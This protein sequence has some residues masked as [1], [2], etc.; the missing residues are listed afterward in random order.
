MKKIFACIV[1]GTIAA[2][3]VVAAD[4]DPSAAQPPPQ[5]KTHSV[6]QSTWPVWLDF[7]SSNSQ[8]LD[9]IGLHLNMPYGAYESITGLDFG[10]YGVVRHMYGLQINILRSDTL[11]FGGGL[12]FSIYNSFGRMDF[13]SIQLGLWN[14]ATSVR[15]IQLGLIN[16]AGSG[17]G[18][19][20]GLINR[21]DDFHGYQFG[22][23]NLIY[24][25]SAPCLPFVNIGF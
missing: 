15:G 22:V 8:T 20:F 5:V 10:F 16:V 19:M 14:E 3:T 24:S 25:A 11:D 13:P 21:A 23:L 17:D 9:V 18:F 2:A 7:N 12:Q 6:K 1:A 4:K